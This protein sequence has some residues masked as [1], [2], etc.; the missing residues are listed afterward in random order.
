MESVIRSNPPPPRPD[1]FRIGPCEVLASIKWFSEELGRV[2][3]S[4]YLC[5][6]SPFLFRKA[7]RGWNFQHENSV[8]IAVTLTGDRNRG[9]DGESELGGPPPP[10]TLEKHGQ[11]KQ[12]C[13]AGK[14]Y[15]LS[16]LSAE[17]R[18]Q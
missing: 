2:R 3:P 1:A 14:G 15:L 9:K 17:Q 7:G 11:V 13:D 12:A 5:L 16:I 10:S 18:M 8:Q 6:L 4:G